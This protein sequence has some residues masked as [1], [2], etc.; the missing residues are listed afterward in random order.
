GEKLLAYKVSGLRYDLGTPLGWIKA[1]IG[2]AS[3][4]PRY[5]QP[6]REFIATLDSVDSF[7]YNQQR[8]LAQQ[9]P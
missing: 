4:D 2:M 1:I 8:I 6:V 5:A 7:V 3:Q 9:Q